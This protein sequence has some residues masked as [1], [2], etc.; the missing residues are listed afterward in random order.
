MTSRASS[1]AR[2]GA[3]TR[4]RHPAGPTARQ[5]RRQRRASPAVGWPSRR[6]GESS[7]PTFIN[8]PG[9]RIPLSTKERR[10]LMNSHLRQLLHAY[11]SRRSP[12]GPPWWI[13]GVAFGAVNLVRQA[14]II[15]TPAE[16]PQSIRVAS[17][18]VTALAV[19]VVINGIA[20][21]LRRRRDPPSRDKRRRS[22]RS[23]HSAVPTH[24]VRS[25]PHHQ[26]TRT[27]QATQ[28][29]RWLTP[30][31]GHRRR[32]HCDEPAT[33]KNRRRRRPSGRPGGC[34]S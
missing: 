24:A 27:G 20:V 10:E 26:P 23:G 19:V 12:W 1:L 4:P 16:I 31:P 21:T 13:Y 3:G 30:S 34:T 17:Y 5:Q 28:P 9:S 32:T 15:L 6:T 33:F 25:R 8:E 22:P 18:L 2:C 11:T 7:L 29:T 14:V